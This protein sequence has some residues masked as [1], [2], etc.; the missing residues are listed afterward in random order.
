MSSHKSLQGEV[1]E[2]S[3]HK[4]LQGEVRELSPHKSFQ[5]EGQELIFSLFL[6]TLG[7]CTHTLLCSP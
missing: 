4:S 2:L 5:G 1:Q 7:M 3:S 6:K